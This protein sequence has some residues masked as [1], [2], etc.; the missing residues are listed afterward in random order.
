MERFEKINQNSCV[1]LDAIKIK[2]ILAM[3][4]HVNIKCSK[5]RRTDIHCLIVENNF[6]ASGEM[7]QRLKQNLSISV[8]ALLVLRN[9]IYFLSLRSR[10]IFSHVL[11]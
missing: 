5:I 10:C 1:W 4:G 6:V 3:H 2:M 9:V 8:D 11:I 7:N